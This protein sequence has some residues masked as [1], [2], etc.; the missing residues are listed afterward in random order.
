MKFDKFK[1]L[2]KGMRSQKEVRDKFIDSIPSSIRVAFFD[3]EITNSLYKEIEVL[4]EELFG[5]ELLDDINYFLYDSPVH[6]WNIIRDNKEYYI[7]NEKGML[8]YFKQV[9]NWED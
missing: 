6:G 2:F 4:S 7:K 9:Y 3:N 1:E 8:K 5:E